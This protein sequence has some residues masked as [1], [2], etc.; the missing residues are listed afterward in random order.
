MK[1]SVDITESITLQLGAL[2]RERKQR[3]ERL[4]SLGIGEPA[5]ETPAPIVEAAVRAMK[6]GFTRYSSPFGLIELREKIRDKLKTDNGIEVEVENILVAPGAKNALSLV[7]MALLQPGDEVIN[8]TPC[9]VSYIPQIQIAEPSAVIHNIDLRKDAFSLDWHKLE[10]VLGN[11]TKA[12]IL[13]FPHNPTG[14]MI[15][16]EELD[17]LAGLV[18]DEDCYVISDEIY[19][20]LNY[21][22]FPHI[23]PA[24][25][26]SLR[27]KVITINGFSKAFSM[28][29]WRIGYLVADQSLVHTV[30]LIQQHLNTNTCTFVQKGAVAAFDLE[31]AYLKS[32]NQEL[33][34]KAGY[35]QKA[36]SSSTSLK[37]VPPQGG[38]FAFLNIA[39][40]GLS[41]DAFSTELLKRENVVVTPGIAFGKNW[42][43]HIRISLV[44]GKA[45]F[46]KGIDLI[47]EF[48]EEL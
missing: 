45:E 15:S 20:K 38:L 40:T 41:S 43:D 4:I 30:S 42:D 27:D 37:L 13:N 44:T 6:D 1:L 46:E 39:G 31:E 17:K 2:A 36:F 22:G 33:A 35:M 19:E 23:S 21:S 47:K 48:A 26:D 7:L 11:L 8:I 18:K 3:G 34:E 9:Y 5:F 14:K 32:Y 10:E 12:I 16:R 28:T 29:G 24:A 25:L